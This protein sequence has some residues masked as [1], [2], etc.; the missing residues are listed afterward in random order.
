MTQPLLFDNVQAIRGMGHRHVR[1]VGELVCSAC[2]RLGT[3]MAA[4]WRTRRK[5]GGSV[6]ESGLAGSVLWS[7]TARAVGPC[8]VWGRKR[9]VDTKNTLPGP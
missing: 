6:P 1:A 8:L 7:L 4:G 3:Q 9:I 5:R 2:L